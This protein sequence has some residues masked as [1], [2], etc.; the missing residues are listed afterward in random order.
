MNKHLGCNESIHTKHYSS[1]LVSARW[2]SN[3]PANRFKSIVFSVNRFRRKIETP[4]L[5]ILPA[6]HQ[7]SSKFW[8]RRFKS[9]Y[10]NISFSVLQ[11]LDLKIV[12][13]NEECRWKRTGNSQFQRFRSPENTTPRW[14]R[15]LETAKTSVH[16][17]CSPEAAKPPYTNFVCQK[18]QNTSVRDSSNTTPLQLD[19]T[20][21]KFFVKLM[22]L[23]FAP[24]SAH[25]FSKS[26]QEW[27]TRWT[28][29]KRIWTLTWTCNRFSWNFDNTNGFGT[30]IRTTDPMRSHKQV[31]T[32]LHTWK[33]LLEPRTIFG[34]FF[35]NFRKWI[36]RE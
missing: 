8:F 30:A 34:K 33:F 12:P 28:D 32:T 35:E 25:T 27:R 20:P 31:Q 36:L 16:W 17:L 26:H 19:F 3:S 22:F 24:N 29:W 21:N 2:I 10:R 13:E 14:F 15:S 7:I 23:T 4:L 11:S 1:F 18:P 6:T 5:L 9:P